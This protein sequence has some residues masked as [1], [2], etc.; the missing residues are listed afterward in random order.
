MERLLKKPFHLFANRERPY[1]EEC[2]IP[3]LTCNRLLKRGCDR[4]EIA[5]TA[6]L[7]KQERSGERMKGD[8]SI[9]SVC[10]PRLKSTRDNDR[11]KSPVFPRTKDPATANSSFI[12]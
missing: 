5:L 9:C 8:V 2:V 3:V 7:L 4:S 10:K 12:Q 1:Q 11:R 6:K